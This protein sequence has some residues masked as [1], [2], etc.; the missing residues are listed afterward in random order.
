MAEKPATGGLLQFD[1]PSPDSQFGDLTAENAERLWPFIE[2][3]PFSGD[4]CWRLGSIRAG[5]PSLQCNS[6]YSTEKSGMPEFAPP[7]PLSKSSKSQDRASARGLPYASGK[8]PF[9]LCFT[10]KRRQKLI[11]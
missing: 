11:I 4:S 1:R 2:Q 7:G 8:H 5:W 10:A 3:F 9:M 6:L